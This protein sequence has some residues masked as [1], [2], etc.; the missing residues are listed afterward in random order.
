MKIRSIIFSFLLSVLTITNAKSQH[1]KLLSHA[2]RSVFADAK[3]HVGRPVI[4]SDS[5]YRSLLNTYVAIDYRFG[6]NSFCRMPQDSVL[7]HPKY[8]I[9]LTHYW[10]HSDTLGNPWGVYGFFAA[11]F[12]V[13]K[14]RFQLG[15]ELASGFSF[16]FN[17][18][19]PLTNPKNDI[20]GASLNVYFNLSLWSALKLGER[21]DL[22][23]SVDFT[24]FSNGTT[25]LP[26]KGLN[27][28]GGNLGLRYHFTFEKDKEAFARKQKG[29]CRQSFK[30]KP[31]NEIR[32]WYGLSGKTVYSP[33]YKAPVYLCST[34][35]SDF[36]RRYGR[37]GA[38]EA[39]LDLFFDYSLVTDFPGESGIP[40]SRFLFLG[41]HAGHEFNVGNSSLAVQTGFYLLKGMH[42]KGNFFI[43]AGLKYEISRNVFINLSLK[44][45]NGLKADYIELGPGYK[46][47][48][49]K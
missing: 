11:P 45:L 8:G 48:I 37:V 16:N 13:N 14:P 34:L 19:D 31:H 24:H 21:L 44:T 2:G 22:F 49:T 28:Y 38:F 36:V 35:S 18:F 46:F 29:D 30:F 10:L 12:F 23:S 7:K 15:F 4:Y 17:K 40:Y 9:G 47:N 43:R 33:D 1:Y 25:K 32:I 27:L 26:N 3:M 6:I 41:M 5:L 39:G 42:A 20:I